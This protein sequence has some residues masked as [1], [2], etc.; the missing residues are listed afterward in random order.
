M[1][2]E[3]VEY[4][5]KGY[6]KGLEEAWN[7]IL[8]DSKSAGSL[9]ELRMILKAKSATI[10]RRVEAQVSLLKKELGVA[11]VAKASAGSDELIEG[12]SYLVLEKRPKIGYALFRYLI[13]EQGCTGLCV[14]RT[15]HDVIKKKYNVD[16]FTHIRLGSSERDS[17]M[18]SSALGIGESI[19][20][21]AN[22]SKLYEKITRFLEANPGSVVLM[23]GAVEF[24]INE[25]EFSKV[26]K[27]IQRLNDTIESTK[28]YMFIIISPNALKEQD[29]A[30]LERE[31]VET[32]SEE[33]T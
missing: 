18:L 13:V 8:S 26:L 3:R 20:T 6:K 29:M 10:D 9:S 19:S 22:L 28:S 1:T 2:D 31:T 17:N 25:N 12:C 30:A 33:D 27:F 23:D 4:F 15:S 21:G 24:L 5:E 7:E 16:S 14:S 32:I 11:E